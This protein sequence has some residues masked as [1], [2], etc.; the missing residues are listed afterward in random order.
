LQRRLYMTV[1]FD[2]AT[3]PIFRDGD[4]YYPGVASLLAILNCGGRAIIFNSAGTTSRQEKLLIDKLTQL[5]GGRII[6]AR[7]SGSAD[8][9]LI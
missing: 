5:F 9:C 1:A 3:Y 2:I 8:M 4:L 7:D 6:Y